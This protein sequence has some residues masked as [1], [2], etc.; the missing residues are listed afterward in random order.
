[1]RGQHFLAVR[2]IIAAAGLARIGAGLAYELL[3]RNRPARKAVEA[4]RSFGDDARGANERTSL[5]V[6]LAEIHV[7]CGII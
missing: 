1:M 5:S 7:R 6:W 3:G 2:A 4:H